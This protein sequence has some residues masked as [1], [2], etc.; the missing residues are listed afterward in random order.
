MSEPTP[1]ARVPETA[2]GRRD[3]AEN[4]LAGPA[5]TNPQDVAD[6]FGWLQVEHLQYREFPLP[7]GPSTAEPAGKNLQPDPAGGVAATTSRAMRPFRRATR[8]VR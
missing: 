2:S 4:S 6:L 8:S 1:L 3:L 7:D 5:P